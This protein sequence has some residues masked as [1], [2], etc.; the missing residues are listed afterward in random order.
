M[1]FCVIKPGSC[2]TLRDEA[3]NRLKEAIQAYKEGE[4]LLSILQ[5]AK[6]YVVL[7]TTLYNKIYRRQNQALYGVIK[8][9]LT[10]EEEELIKN[11]VL[12]IQL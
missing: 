7:K 5:A 2:I 10:L 11:W 8:Q 1:P 4:G 12:D 3:R 9:R 6:L